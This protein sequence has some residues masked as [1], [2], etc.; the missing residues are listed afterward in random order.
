MILL[1]SLER[2][3]FKITKDSTRRNNHFQTF[4]LEI[5]IFKTNKSP[6]GLQ[7][8]PSCAVESSKH[9]LY[10]VRLFL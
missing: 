7:K 6:A 1:H 10:L 4:E 5:E 8:V 3:G 9:P 2:W